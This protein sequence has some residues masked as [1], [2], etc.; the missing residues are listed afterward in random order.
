MDT[1]QS[2]PS[3]ENLEYPK[4]KDADE[5]SMLWDEYK[6]RHDLI[7]RHLIRSTLALVALVTV[8]YST[9]FKPTVW[10]VIVAWVVALGYWVVTLFAVEPELRLFKKIKDLHRERQTRYFG[11]HG[12]TKQAWVVWVATHFGLREKT[13]QTN[14]TKWGKVFLVDAFSCRVGTYLF[15]LLVATLL[16]GLVALLD[17]GPTL[18]FIFELEV[19]LGS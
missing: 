11:F 5:G 2:S 8:R 17:K 14:D 10:L 1:H 13:K 9:A 15:L 12:K 18:G 7:W 6:Y 19:R 16:V 3:Q 4:L